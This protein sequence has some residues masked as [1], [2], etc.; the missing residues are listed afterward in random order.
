MS[1]I[2]AGR[3]ADGVLADERISGGIGSER[4]GSAP[5]SQPP[6]HTRRILMYCT[7]DSVRT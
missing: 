6:R 3:N 4:D 1:E 7:M 2:T 5:T